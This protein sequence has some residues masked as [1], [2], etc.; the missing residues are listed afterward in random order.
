MKAQSGFTLIELMVA[1]ALGLIITAAAIALLLTGQKSYSLQQGVADL[2]DNA[3]FGLN[4]IARDIRLSNLNTTVAEVNDETAYGGIVLTSSENA[5]KAP[6]KAP[7]VG[8]P[9]SNLYKSIKDATADEALLS[10]SNGQDGWSG[11]SNVQAKEDGEG[12]SEESPNYVD[13]YSDQ[14]VIQYKPQ[15][16]QEG[17]NWFGG[18]DCEGNKIEFASTVTTGGVTKDAPLRIIVQRYFLREDSSKNAR[19]PNMAL[20]L[21]CDAGWYN[22]SGNPSKVERYGD[23]GQII[24]K[25]VDHFRVLLGIQNGGSHRYISIKDYMEL[26]AGARPRILSVQ[27]GILARSAQAISKDSL[28]KDDQEF[29]VLD[30]AVKV[31]EPAINTT[32][33]VRQVVSQTVALRNTFGER[34]K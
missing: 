15:Y 19:E 5:T 21:A 1:L 32:K 24:M 2:Q 4:Y 6:A 10:R 33:H 17:N 20:A 26:D 29:Q 25:R 30:Q 12:A 13:I 28:I 8:D 22:E 27:L 34:G 11:N 31:K 16:I 3:N 23:A 14:L 9:L 7:A 18:Y